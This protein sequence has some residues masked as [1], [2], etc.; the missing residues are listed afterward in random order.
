MGHSWRHFA[1]E[2]F[3]RRKILRENL[4]PEVPLITWLAKVEKTCRVKLSL[5]KEMAQRVNRLFAIYSM[6][7]TTF[8]LEKRETLCNYMYKQQTKDSYAFYELDSQWS[9]SQRR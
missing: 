5:D 7:I 2:R 8:K 6:N 9:S 3:A 1:I 4:S